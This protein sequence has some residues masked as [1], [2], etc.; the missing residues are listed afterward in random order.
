[1]IALQKRMTANGF[2]TDGADGVIG[3]NSE[4]AIRADQASRGLTATGTPSL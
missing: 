3:T 1:M 2:D 4:K